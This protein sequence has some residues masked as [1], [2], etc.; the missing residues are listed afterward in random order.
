MARKLQKKVFIDPGTVFTEDTSECS[1]SGDVIYVIGDQQM[2]N[3]ID[4]EEHYE[5]EE[6]VYQ[7]IEE[8]V[9][10]DDEVYEVIETNGEP[11][12]Y[13]VQDEVHDEAYEEYASSENIE[14]IEIISDVNE[15]VENEEIIYVTTEDVGTS[16]SEE[17][18]F[19]QVIFEIKT[20]I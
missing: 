8:V 2:V 4:Y 9:D 3:Q 18:T 15:G 6:Q 16:E 19:M 7:V 14:S 5:G 10:A 11:D 13:I 20:K 1:G 17:V 12:K